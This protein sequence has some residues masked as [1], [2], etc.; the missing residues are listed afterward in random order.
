[1]PECA[2]ERKGGH[3]SILS[4]ACFN[5]LWVNYVERAALSPPHCTDVALNT[6]QA[7]AILKNTV[8]V[9]H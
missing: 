4:V 5:L 8:I 6:T 2:H 9:F 7:I 1:M 3:S